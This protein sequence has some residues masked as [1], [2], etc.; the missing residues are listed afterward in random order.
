MELYWKGLIK[1]RVHVVLN[2]GYEYNGL[3]K[4]VED[5]KNGLIFI[6]LLD[7]FDKEVIFVSGEIK[8]LEVKDD[9]RNK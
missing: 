2:N 9:N 3:I 4:S 7:K 6:Y 5:A 1:K 8:F